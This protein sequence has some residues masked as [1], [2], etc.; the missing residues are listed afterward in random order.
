M[1]AGVR[2]RIDIAKTVESIVSDHHAFN[3][4][5]SGWFRVG[6]PRVRLAREETAALALTDSQDVFD[7]RS[8]R[9]SYHAPWPCFYIEV[10]SATLYI[11]TE[12][13]SLEVDRILMHQAVFHRDAS[14]E[15]WVTAIGCGPDLIA[16][17]NTI[18]ALC[19]NKTDATHTTAGYKHFETW[20]KRPFTEYSEPRLVSRPAC[21]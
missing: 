15:F 12:T 16:V 13:K 19:E 21:A 9:T 20:A 4:W 10:P 3:V 5:L 14:R 7:A 11:A 18:L 2:D 1:L 17:P 8:D 6:C